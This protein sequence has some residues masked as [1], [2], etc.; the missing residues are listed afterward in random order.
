MPEK[1]NKTET[2]SIID[3]YEETVKQCAETYYCLAV[4][5]DLE[6]NHQEAS[7]YIER[8]RQLDP[9]NETYKNYKTTHQTNAPCLN[10]D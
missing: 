1:Q 5:A 9:N 7:G 3:K 10:Q 6:F 4:L 8:A 2:L